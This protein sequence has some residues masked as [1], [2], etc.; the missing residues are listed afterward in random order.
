M[1]AVAAVAAAPGA[2]AML[3]LPAPG[4][5]HPPHAPTEAEAMAFSPLEDEVRTILR[6]FSVPYIIWEDMATDGYHTLAD[7]AD[8]WITKESCREKAAEDLG[9][10]EGEKGYT[11]ATA[12]RAIVRIAQAVEEAK[13]RTKA[14]STVIAGPKTNNGARMIIETMGREALEL[15]YAA[16]AYGRMPPLS[17]QGSNTFT[18]KLFRE[19]QNGR[20]PY[21]EYKEAT[22]FLPDPEMP[23]KKIN[24][25]GGSGQAST[26]D[27]AE[28]EEVLE[29][30]RM[31][32]LKK[33]WLVIHTDDG[34]IVTAAAP[35]APA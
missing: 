11:K 9:I 28:E 6:N 23:T 27:Y 34:D 1:A 14:R 31:E 20:L 2:A 7:L 16:K 10:K 15:A 29:I 18:G 30:T 35:S 4:L 32:S 33:L 24:K 13:N 5:N 8:R 3:A 17:C 26:D 21:F 19:C 25:A 22:P 12:G